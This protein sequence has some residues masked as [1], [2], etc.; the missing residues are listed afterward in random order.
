[1]L[2]LATL[3]NAIAGR[4]RSAP[5]V[6]APPPT[7]RAEVAERT[8]QS[9]AAVIAPPV[10]TWRRIL[11]QAVAIWLAT[12]LAYALFTYVAVMF[13]HA[14]P[15][16]EFIPVPPHALLATWQRWDAQ[17]YIHIAQRGYWNEQPTA[18]FPLYPLLIK[19]AALLSGQH[20][21][22][23]AVLVSNLGSLAA[24]V[25]VGL[26][27]AH[28]DSSEAAAWR[29]VRVMLAYPLAFFLVAPYTEGL[30]LGFAALA[31]YAGRRGIWGWAAL[32]AF[33]AG[34]TR[35]T[36]IILV[37]ALAWE[38]GRQRGWWVRA[39][40]WLRTVTSGGLATLPGR[41]R[42][43]T[44]PE[45]WIG[46]WYAVRARWRDAAWHEW[47][48]WRAGQWRADPQIRT[49]LGGLA[50]IAAVPGAMM[51]YMAFLEVR[52]RHPLLWFHVQTIFWRR[53]SMPLISAI[54][55]AISQ[56]LDMRPWTYWQARDLVDLAPVL[57]FGLLTLVTIRKAPFAFTLFMAGLIYLAISSPVL[58][59]PDPDMLISAGR[60]LVAAAPM[61]VLLGRWT[62]RRPWLD[63]MLVS[64]GFLTQA[65]LASFFLAYGWLI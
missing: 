16:M 43:L 6:A 36:G 9:T 65:I 2:H 14:G 22:F 64:G 59:S 1:M 63:L 13:Q 24:I 5:A 23:A 49:L 12:R 58:D 39:G 61:W 32:W 15:A 33:L 41:V 54:G 55:D 42:A 10:V 57:I 44:R 34:L 8:R 21:L 3:R 56:V 48:W 27:A 47:S 37:P 35:P 30:F 31:L 46:A 26:L 19:V 60:F 25:G 53:D 62:E 20:W 29:A 11:P 7:E 50:A 45:P 40:A 52:F 28:E 18:F 38:F 4:I 51:V 17:W